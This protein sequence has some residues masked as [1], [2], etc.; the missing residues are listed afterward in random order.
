MADSVYC[1]CSSEA[2]AN[3][4][5]THLRNDGFGQEISVFLQD[6]S[7]TKDMSLKEN[8]I[9]DAGIGSVVGALVSLAVPGLGPVLALGPLLGILNGAVAGGV[10]GGLIGGSGALKP[11]GLPHEVA[12]RLH[13]QFSEGN[14]LV[15]VHSSDPHELDKALTVFKSE[16]ATEIY[17][18]RKKAAST[19]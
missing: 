5:L 13:H 10:V 14:I 9:R 19:I 7:D 15:S 3:A 8:A 16:G 1:S 6:R 2:L 11:L 18:S 12:E 17:D 4:I